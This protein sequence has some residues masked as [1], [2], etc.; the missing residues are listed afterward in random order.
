MLP[1][2]DIVQPRRAFNLTI[3]LRES[4][5]SSFLS[6]E[7]FVFN[8]PFARRI[9]RIRNYYSCSAAERNIA[10]QSVQV[11]IVEGPVYSLHVSACSNLKLSD[12]SLVLSLVIDVK[13]TYSDMYTDMF[14]Y[15]RN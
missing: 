8:R 4:V 5:A 2:F 15:G 1:G 13:C 14:R 10:V 11:V 9:V 7:R 3:C 12:R 6:Q